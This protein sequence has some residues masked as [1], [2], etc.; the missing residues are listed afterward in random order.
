MAD[1][2]YTQKYAS[3]VVYVGQSALC[4]ASMRKLTLPHVS[5][6]HRTNIPGK[7]I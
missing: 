3:H 5:I 4:H 7:W 2:D 6:S 1:T